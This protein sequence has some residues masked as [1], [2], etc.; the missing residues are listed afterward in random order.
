MRIPGAL[1]E[2]G[3]EPGD[4]DD[5]ELSLGRHAVRVLIGDADLT[6]HAMTGNGVL[7]WQ[8]SLSDATP[9]ALILAAIDMTTANVAIRR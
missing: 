5:F 6:V 3:F 2:R 1:Q 9:Y 8:A 7:L 4:R